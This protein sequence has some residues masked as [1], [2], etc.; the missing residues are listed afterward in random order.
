LQFIIEYSFFI[1]NDFL[2]SIKVHCRNSRMYCIHVMRPYKNTNY[3][4]FNISGW[5]YTSIFD[6][7]FIQLW[8]NINYQMNTLCSSTHEP[9]FLTCSLVRATVTKEGSLQRRKRKGILFPKLFLPSVKKNCSINRDFF[10]Y[11]R[12]K[13]KNLHHFWNRI[14]F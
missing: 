2:S 9:T 7:E 8:W 4:T 12:L 5:S 10:L 11:S 14:L 6:P 13:V 3:S 1:Y